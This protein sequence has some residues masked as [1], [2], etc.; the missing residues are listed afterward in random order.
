MSSKQHYDTVARAIEYIHSRARHQ[1]TLAEVA[2]AV[3]SSESHLQRIFSAWA[4]ISPKRFLQY[5]TKE[6][7]LQALHNADDLLSV[8]LDSGLSSPGRLHDLMI[9]C[10]AMTPGEIKS[11]GA[12]VQIGYGYTDTPFGT[13]LIGWTARG[14]CYLA[15]CSGDEA[16]R[17]DELKSQWCAAQSAEDSKQA[18]QYGAQIFPTTPIPGKLHLVLRGTNF[19]IKVWEALLKVEPGQLVSYGQLAQQ[20][21][22]PNAQRAVGTAVAKNNIGFLIPCHRVIKGTGESGNYRWGSTRKRAMHVWEG[23]QHPLMND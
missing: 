2:S 22:I 20:L 9:S 14:I 3:G 19:Q 1:P 4:G 16:E 8:S 5:L 11:G 7:A 15:F 17:L 13:A 12:G 23:G 21:G 6:Y 10:E 18:A